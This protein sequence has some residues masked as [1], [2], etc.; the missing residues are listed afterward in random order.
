M[1]RLKIFLG[2]LFLF[3]LLTTYLILDFIFYFPKVVFFNVGQG[4][5]VGIFN[6]YTFLLYDVGPPN[7]LIKN[8]HRFL[9]LGQKRIDGII[10]S[11]YD[12]DHYGEIFNLLKNYRI[13]FL[14]L[15]EILPERSFEK[16]IK[17]LSPSTKIIQAKKG[18]TL[19]TP[20]EFLIFLNDASQKRT[21]NEKS[22]VVKLTQFDNFSRK[23]DILL[24]GDLPSTLKEIFKYDL[25]SDILLVPHHGSRYSLSS[26]LLRAVQ[27]QLAVIQVG[28]NRYG[29]PHQETINL[30]E[31]FNIP[32]WRT[33]IQGELILP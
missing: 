8:L 12:K 27:P 7:K 10:I 17:S 20:Y 3:F 15:N 33:D 25:K 6:R 26:D 5:A 29:H 4:N 11:H 22:L 9:L 21:D 2:F 19:K 24:M 14:I 13:R 16:Q 30:L 1:K 28:L 18:M 31:K 23:K 32:F